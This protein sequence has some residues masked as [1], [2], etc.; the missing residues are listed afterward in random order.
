MSHVFQRS[1]AFLFLLSRF[2][3]FLLLFERLL[4]LCYQTL[5]TDTLTLLKWAACSVNE[6]NWYTS[7]DRRPQSSP[8]RVVRPLCV[9]VR[10]CVY[11]PDDLYAV[12]TIQPVVKPVI[13]P[14]AVIQPVWQTAASCRQTSNRLSNRFDNRFD[15]RL[16]RVNGLK[17]D[18]HNCLL[19][20]S[21]S[22]RD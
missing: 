11:S 7:F 14:V 5:V 18:R 12:Y 20:T 6:N 13:Q 9:C 21:P 19:Y 3:T 1:C 10:V 4:H 16:Y 15:N 2:K 17:S 8:G 22:P